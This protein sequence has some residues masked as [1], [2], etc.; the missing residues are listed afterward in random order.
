MTIQSLSAQNIVKRYAGTL[1]LADGNLEVHS[2]EVVGLVGSNGSGKSTLCKVITGVVAPNGGRLLLDGRTL[3]FHEPYDALKQGIAAVYQELSLVPTMTVDRNIWLFHEPVKAGFLIDRQETRRRT[4][5]LIDLFAGTVSSALTPDA[6]VMDLSPDERQIVEILKT[7]SHEPEMLILDE[8]TSSLDNRQVTRLFELVAGWKSQGKAVVFIS[9]RLSEVFQIADRVVV[10]RNGTTVGN[11]DKGELNERKLVRLIVGEEV[12]E[13]ER[14]IVKEVEQEPEVRQRPVILR[15]RDLRTSVVKSVSFDLREGELLGIGGLQ[16]QGQP[17]VLLAIFGAVP[18]AGEILLK[19]QSKHYSHPSEAMRDGLALIPGDRSTEGLLMRTSILENLE[20]PSWGRYGK[21]L[22]LERARQDAQATAESLDIKMNS[23]DMP[24]SY[25]SGGNAQKVVI[26]K[27][28]QR[29]PSLLLL[30]D[31]TKGVDVG[32]KGEFYNLV[33]SLQKEGTSI[34][35]Y[36]SDDEELVQLCERVLVMSGGE[37]RAELQGDNLS[38]S[39]LVAA[40]LGA[41]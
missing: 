24:V 11:F 37:I 14:E 20:L 2:G 12:L 29:S 40:S 35:L 22:N 30:N 19:E 41:E 17:H 23:L 25:L 13:I 8:A 10:F 38:L 27:W 6:L 31:P 18:Y 28:L 26:G 36:S 9:H 3:E 33:H 5:A 7:I 21:L 4:R 16:G 39:S 34:I 1:A 15:V 32:A